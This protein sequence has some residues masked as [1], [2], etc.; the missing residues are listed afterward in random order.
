MSN[1]G[2]AYTYSN[3]GLNA[4]TVRTGT[5]Y[6]YVHTVDRGSR[7]YIGRVVG[8]AAAPRIAEGYTYTNTGVRLL[9]VLEGVPYIYINQ[10][11]QVSGGDRTM[12]DGAVRHLEDGTTARTLE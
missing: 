7:S 5:F 10:L 6:V 4:V 1:A 3:V 9:T 11:E 12:E 8:F 2:T